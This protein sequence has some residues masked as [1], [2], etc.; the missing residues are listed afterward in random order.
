[1]P[2]SVVLFSCIPAVCSTSF[3]FSFGHFRNKVHRLYVYLP[4]AVCVQ[5]L[6]LATTQH[7]NP[8]ITKHAVTG[9]RA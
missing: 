7:N 2:T 5:V 9:R 1:M 6:T 3:C 4:P 8:L